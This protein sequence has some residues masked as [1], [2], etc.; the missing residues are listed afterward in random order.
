M[1]FLMSVFCLSSG[2][3]Q[4]KKQNKSV[5][6]QIDNHRLENL[7]GSQSKIKQQNVLIILIKN[8]IFRQ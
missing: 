3:I 6:N 2:T 1:A 4:K 8:K 7:L 5:V